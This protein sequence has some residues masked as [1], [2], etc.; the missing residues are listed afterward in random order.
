MRSDVYGFGVVLLEMMTGSIAFDKN[1]PSSEQNLVEFARGSLSDKKKLKKIMDSRMDG[2]YSMT[3]AF[4]IAQLI[5]KCIESDPKNRPSMEDVLETLE[6]A[7]NT[8]FKPKEK[9]TNKRPEKHSSHYQHR[10]PI[11]H[12]N[13]Y[14]KS[15]SHSPQ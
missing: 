5:L 7:K 13:S 11:H 4:Q 12:N 8:K 6:K 15:R 1:R 10:S 2:Q 14:S 9:K 3:A